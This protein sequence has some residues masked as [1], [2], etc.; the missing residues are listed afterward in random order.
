MDRQRQQN[1]KAHQLVSGALIVAGCLFVAGAMF[2]GRDGPNTH[3]R[4]LAI[5][6]IAVFLVGTV[7]WLTARLVAWWQD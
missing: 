6:G 1:L 5:T 3:T 7:W 2:A 4:W